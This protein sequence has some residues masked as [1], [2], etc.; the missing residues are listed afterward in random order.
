M[1]P[2]G[3]LEGGAAAS[4]RRAVGLALVALSGASFGALGLFGKAAY[5]AGVDV[6][7][8]LMLR[9]TLAGAILFALLFVRGERLPRGRLLVALVG[10]GAVGYVSESLA[11]FYALKYA[12]A[13]LV[14]LLLYVYPALVALVSVALGR[15]R[16]NRPRAIALV[17][18]LAGTALT[19]DPSGG[20][21]PLGVVL[22]LLS[23]V[24][25]TAYILVSASVL[26]RVDALPASAVI[27]SS[28]G[29]VYGGAVL[30]R[31]AAWP[32]TGAGWAAVGGLVVVSTV[33]AALAFLA[34]L[35]RVGAVTTSMLSTL[36]PAG[37]VV[38]GAL[39]L[40]ERLS[41]VQVLGG[42]LILL[43]VVLLSRVE[44]PAPP[45]SH[46]H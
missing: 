32:Q 38:L 35:K 43:A 29:V 33:I 3:A 45:V 23:A 12:S 7:T 10:L 5:A 36:E 30:A 15:E 4:R 13:G 18:A 20:A 27:L 16:L 46:E 37:A 31:G 21:R 8:L 34:G 26:E 19:I 6:P 40:G 22:G 24:I 9:F 44:P 25:Y 17:L 41:T 42:A 39:F 2:A 14:A 28:T 1:T 11:Y